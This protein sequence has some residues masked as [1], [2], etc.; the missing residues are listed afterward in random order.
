MSD[1]AP[2]PR[3]KTADVSDLATQVEQEHVQ[4]QLLAHAKKMQRDQEPDANGVFSFPCCDYCGVEI[5]EGRLR[6]AIRNK[7][8]I[9]C[10]TKAE[11]R[12]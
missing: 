9:Y 10:A 1:Q 12:V 3:E 6:A 5:G 7:L 8:C 4:L 11:R 2:D